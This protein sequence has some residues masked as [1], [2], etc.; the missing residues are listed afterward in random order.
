MK[1]KLLFSFLEISELYLRKKHNQNL[2]YFTSYDRENDSTLEGRNLIA[3]SY[4]Q[5][6]L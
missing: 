5:K 4:S 3:V 2:K 1:I 6:K